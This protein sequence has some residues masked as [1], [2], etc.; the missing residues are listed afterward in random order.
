MKNL[1]E[2]LN[3]VKARCAKC[4]AGGMIPKDFVKAWVCRKC[5]KA[6]EVK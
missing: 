5:K 1:N 2:F 4:G 3:V 6:G